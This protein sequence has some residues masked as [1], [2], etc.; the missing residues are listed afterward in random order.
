VIIDLAIHA[1]QVLAAPAVYAK[2]QSSTVQIAAKNPEFV[3]EYNISV[4]L[5]EFDA[6]RHA[7]VNVL[8]LHVV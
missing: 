5:S 7:N 8:L 6:A 3:A 4:Q 1:E 2:F